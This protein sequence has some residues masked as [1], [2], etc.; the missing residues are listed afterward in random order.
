MTD[1][2]LLSLDRLFDS[3]EFDS[4]SFGPARWLDDEAGYTTLEPSAEDEKVKEIIRY[5]I[6]TGRRSVLVTAEQLPADGEEKPLVIDDY[7]WSPDKKILLLFTNSERVWREKNRGD[8]WLLE[9]DNGRLL[10]LGGEA[11]P[12]TL[13]F[14]KFSPDSQ[15][16][17]LRA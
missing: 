7:E 13:M 3:K 12:S 6:Q 5:D 11:K 1:K 14:A 2:A 15:I 17:R 16:G 8:Y 4:N 9:I 10:K